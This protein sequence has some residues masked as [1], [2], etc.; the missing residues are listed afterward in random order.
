MK[1]IWFEPG[2]SY[3][4]WIQDDPVSEGDAI[5]EGEDPSTVKGDEVTADGT[6]AFGPTNIWSIP[7]EAPITYQEYDII[8]DKQEVSGTGS[9]NAA[10]DGIDD[11]TV[12]GIT[13]P[14]PEAS[15]LV[16]LMT[17]LLCLFSILY[18]RRRRER[19]I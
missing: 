17:G 12:A 2:I 8:V 9:Y 14:I 18:L 16:L 11:A 1:G 7:A 6:G 10:D 5:A 3:K 15:T 4:I 13:A 19:Q